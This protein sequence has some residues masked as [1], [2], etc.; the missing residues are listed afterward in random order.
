VPEPSTD[1][2]P[3]AM[4]GEGADLGKS[5]GARAAFSRRN[6]RLLVASAGLL[7][8]FVWLL[9]AGGLPLLPPKGALDAVDA[10][11]VTGFALLL[12][13]QQLLRFARCHFLIAPIARLSLR[14]L[15]TINGIA[16]ALITFLP[17]RIGEVSRP[18]ML[19]EKGHLSAWAVTGTV[20]AERI[21][22]G[23]VFSAM[24]L[25]G[26]AIARP[27][28]PL[29]S[30]IGTLPVPASL[31][32]RIAR[33]ASIGFAGAFVVMAAFY[34]HRALARRI[35]ERVVGI[36]SPTIG[37]KLADVVEA[38]SDGLRFLRNPRYSVPYIAVSVV[39][40]VAHV[41]AMQLL[42]RA[43]GIP[44]LTFSEAMVV[45]GVLALGFGMPNAPGFFG[46]V[47]LALYGGL[48]VYISP[49][50]LVHA[51]AA[52]VYIFYVA[53]IAQV[54]LIAAVSAIVEYAAR[55]EPKTMGSIEHVGPG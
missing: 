32:P 16:L 21:L 28:E 53:Y 31:V 24:L 29:P 13:L 4:D 51:G 20:G 45:V 5:N 37:R 30:H 18:A 8:A 9:R 49:E 11:D 26:L 48:A 3:E 6:V 52:L 44:E 43:V 27:H 19:R 22:D 15:M 46:T 36:I 33:L 54:I 7:G 25:L 2:S 34:W 39:A 12:L 1:E 50:K 40:T 23:V 41:W 38:L 17:L 35:T 55:P 10:V 14:R 42:A 47:Q